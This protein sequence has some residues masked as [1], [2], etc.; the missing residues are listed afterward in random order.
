MSSDTWEKLPDEPSLWYARFENYRLL[1]PERTIEAAWR[2]E[3]RA[4]QSKA[5]RVPADWYDRSATWR[6][7]ERAEAWDALEREKVRQRTQK[8]LD[9]SRERQV[10]VARMVQQ[11]VIERISRASVKRLRL[12]ELWRLF[13]EA[14]A[15]EQQALAEPML[16]ELRR[17]MALLA[18]RLEDLESASLAAPARQAESGSGPSSEPGS[19]VDG[20]SA[21]S[22][23]T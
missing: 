18:K 11:K 10:V 13:D 22:S 9:E 5:K 15:L 1:G 14:T 3:A 6:W 16:A 17:K 23:P 12:T 21:A 8:E 7:K 4:G 20:A 2:Q 19:Q